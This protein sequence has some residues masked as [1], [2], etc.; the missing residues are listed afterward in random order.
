MS[1][2][3]AEQDRVLQIPPGMKGPLAFSGVFHV[4]L[5]IIAIV[6]LPYFK[7]PPEPMTRAIAV[8]ILPIA[9]ITTTNRIPTKAPPK[10]VEEL[11]EKPKE[12]PVTPPK[13]ETVQPPKDLPKPPQEKPKPKPKPV[14]PPPPTK[15]LAPPEP[16]PVEKPKPE[17]KPVEQDQQ[18]DFSSLLKNLQESKPDVQEDL[19]EAKVADAPAPAP[20]APF[21]QNLTMSEFDLL[22]QQLQRCWSIQA[23]ARYAEDLVVE[24]RV[25]VNRERRVL[26]AAIVDQ[27]RYGQDSYF[28][29]AADSAI[30]AINSPQCE[31]LNVPPDKYDIWKDMIVTFD[32]RDML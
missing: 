18:E 10:P 26:S 2:T 19:P 31:I 1:A 28:R 16:K 12:K 11:K 22:T 3:V 27:W 6:G 32:P 14:V 25:I 24:V 9:D 30:R 15:E 4:A 5:V 8:E 23:G 17:E 29:A 21:S 13:V 20:A 7:A